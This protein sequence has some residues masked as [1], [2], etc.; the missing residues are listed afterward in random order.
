MLFNSLSFL[1]FFPIVF[2]L[3]WFV[4]P[5]KRKG[6]NIMLLVASCYF[7]ATW[8]YKF[9]FLLLFSILLDFFSA[10]KIEQARQKSAKKFWLTLSIGINLGFLAIF[11]YYNFF[12]DSLAD[13]LS[14]IGFSAH[15]E[16]L[17]V[18]LPVGISFYTFHGLSYII[19]VYKERIK[20]ERNFIDY[21]LFVAYFP[22]LVA[23][24]IE[25]ATHLLPQIKAS[26]SFEYEKM[27]SGTK[28]II[29]G[30]FK[31]VVVADNCSFFVN[32]IFGDFQH[33]TS[34]ELF[35]GMLLFSFQIYGDFSGYSDIAI[36]VS[37]LMGIDLLINFKFPYFSKN[38]ADF[39]KRWHISLS[40][41]FR[42]YL[43]IPLGGSKTSK[44]QHIKNVFIVFLVSGFWHGAN[45]TFIFWGLLHA[46]LFVPLLFLPDN[47]TQ[48]NQSQLSILDYFKFCI[49]FILVSLLWVI[50]RANS[51][52][53]AYEYLLR[54][55]S[56]NGFEPKLFVT[57][58]KY[59]L[60][61]GLTGLSVLFML[62]IEFSCFRK[63]LV[64]VNF[65]K[66][67]AVIVILLILLMGAFR[68]PMS[69]IY[70][71]F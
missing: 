67:T 1:V 65:S 12:A 5:K 20:A 4:F 68:N 70:F 46:L 33:K 19:D 24:P 13:L 31:K 25:R 50:F 7:Y 23:G 69:F 17:Q 61:F 18:I 37:K 27:V 16:T 30:L 35:L 6:Q 42:D 41:W 52:S 22:L 63:N 38:I 60:L 26:R 55:L 2:I 45:W 51:I 34:T 15:F 9:L 53:E 71:Q 11:K 36:G 32:Q 39:W 56:F 59:L 62:G 54:M 10:L 8:N 29:W 57:N 66:Y 14:N 58:A 43:Y 64:V 40:S 48:Y 21:G 47:P 3:Y 28:L 49:T 44:T